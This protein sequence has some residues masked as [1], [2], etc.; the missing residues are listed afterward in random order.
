[1]LTLLTILY[2]VLGVASMAF[3]LNDMKEVKLSF[4]KFLVIIFALLLWPLYWL[5]RK[6]ISEGFKL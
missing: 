6:L 1:M 5:L 2:M 4:D 3:Y